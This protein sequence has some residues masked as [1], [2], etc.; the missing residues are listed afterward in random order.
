MCVKFWVSNVILVCVDDKTPKIFNIA[1]ISDGSRTSRGGGQLPRQ[2]VSRNLYVKTKESGPLGG[3]A[4][5]A[6]CI[7]H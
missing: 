1:H 2:L 6:P 4:G 7:R 3:G 5:G